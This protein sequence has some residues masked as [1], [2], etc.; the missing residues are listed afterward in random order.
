MFTYVAYLLCADPRNTDIA[1][2]HLFVVYLIN[3]RA[4]K[5][6]VKLPYSFHR[7]FVRRTFY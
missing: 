6:A 3:R 4:Q 7:Y 1:N 5:K 2:E